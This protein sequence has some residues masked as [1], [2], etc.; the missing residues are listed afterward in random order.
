L[1]TRFFA[2]SVAQ[3]D[4]ERDFFMRAEASTEFTEFHFGAGEAAIARVVGE[5]EALGRNALVL[6]EEIEN[7]LH[8]L[9]V[10]RLVDYL[11]N[12]AKDR[13]IQI[14]FTTHSEYA[15]ANLPDS[16]I[17]SCL[18]GIVRQGRLDI[19]S[20]KALSGDIPTK[21]AIFVEDKFAVKWVEK[22]VALYGGD[23]VHEVSVHA[24]SGADNAIS[25]HKNHGRNPS[26]DFKSIC[27]L[28]SDAESPADPASGIFKLPGGPHDD[29]ELTVFASVIEKLGSAEAGLKAACHIPDSTPLDKIVDSVARTTQDA[30]LLFARLAEFVGT[31]DEDEIANGFIFT[32]CQ[33]FEAEAREIVRRIMAA[34]DAAP[35]DNV[36]PG[37]L[38]ANGR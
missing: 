19:A 12:K 23:R 29:P 24:C 16:A 11:V 13:S 6:I 32:W 17:W 20:L 36:D 1:D 33:L 37:K 5:I 31:A 9:A 14:I 7:G 30:H 27:L 38:V 4:A 22:M 15:I 21:L 18:N 28:D 8:P 35:S 10:Q 3:V 25:I 34:V 2:L 26:I